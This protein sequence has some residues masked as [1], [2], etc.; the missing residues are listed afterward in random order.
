MPVVSSNTQLYQAPI[1]LAPKTAYS[2]TFYAKASMARFV[3][4]QM[5][6]NIA[7]YTNYGLNAVIPLSTTWQPYTLQFTSTNPAIVSDARLKFMFNGLAGNGDTYYFVSVRP[8]T[9]LTGTAVSPN[10]L[11]RTYGR[12]ECSGVGA[13][14]VER[15]HIRGVSSR[16]TRVV[17]AIPGRQYLSLFRVPLVRLQSVFGGRIEGPVLLSAHSEWISLRASPS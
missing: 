12:G 8:T 15:V 4:V 10:L 9:P 1:T 2:L 17:P 13:V 7:P 5:H 11:N 3:S 16:R 6:Q 14:G